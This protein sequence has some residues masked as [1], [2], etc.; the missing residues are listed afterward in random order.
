MMFQGNKQ[1]MALLLSVGVV[2]V[3]LPFFTLGGVWY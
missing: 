2:S 3:H 1:K